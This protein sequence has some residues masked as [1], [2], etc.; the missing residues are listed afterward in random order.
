[1]KKIF[2]DKGE[3]RMAGLLKTGRHFIRT[4]DGLRL[5]LPLWRYDYPV[6]I[7]NLIQY[8]PDENI[9]FPT[10]GDL[11]REGLV[12]EEADFREYEIF[13]EGFCD[14]GCGHPFTGKV[15]RRII[16]EFKEHG[17]DVSREA[18]VHN[19]CAWV[20]DLK[21]GYRD[22]TNGYH[23]FT[24]CGCNALRF[25]ATTLSDDTDWQTTYEA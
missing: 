15:V 9:A 2:T 19:Y 21:S 11:I 17:F 25:S 20:Q 7:N 22:E 13:P 5:F 6:D 14:A 12:T 3:A 16:A 24:P 23:L 4:S 1:M 18:L 8:T 10:L